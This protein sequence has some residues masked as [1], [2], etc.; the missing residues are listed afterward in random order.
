MEWESSLK[1]RDM[2]NAELTERIILLE[3]ATNQLEGDNRELALKLKDALSQSE[4]TEFNSKHE[5]AQLKGKAL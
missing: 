5:R 1:D 2:R 3:K 4:G